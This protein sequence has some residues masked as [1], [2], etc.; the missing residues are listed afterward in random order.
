MEMGNTCETN[1]LFMEKEFV[2]NIEAS[3]NNKFFFMELSGQ[4]LFYTSTV[5]N[6]F[7]KFKME[8]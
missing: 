5:K 1:K 6:H 8:I 4:D 3:K 7:L 2:Q